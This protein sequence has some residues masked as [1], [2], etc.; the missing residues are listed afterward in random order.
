MIRVAISGIPGR[1]ATATAA[2]IAASDGSRQVTM[3]SSVTSYSNRQ[4][5]PL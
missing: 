2:G 1:L 3:R 5:R 4:N